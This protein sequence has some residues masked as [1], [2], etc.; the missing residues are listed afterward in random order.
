MKQGRLTDHV[1]G[2]FV[3]HETAGCV[4]TPGRGIT[5]ARRI[6]PGSVLVRHF[7]VHVQI[8]GAGH[9][10]CLDG[11]VFL[12]VMDAV[13]GLIDDLDLEFFGAEKVEEDKKD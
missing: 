10:G 6:G 1:H 2:N 7:P 4:L 11:G 8:G 5:P 13:E 3:D 9:L 12:L